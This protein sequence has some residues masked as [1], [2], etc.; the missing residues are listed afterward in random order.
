MVLKDRIRWFRGATH[1]VAAIEFALIAPALL[2]IYVGGSELA[3]GMMNSRRVSLLARTVA[4]LTSLGDTAS[5]MATATMADIFKASTLVLS[6]FPATGA[7]MR[8][9]AIGIYMVGATRTVRI[10]SSAG[11]NI[12]ALPAGVAPPSLKVPASY[13]RHG[14][15]L[16]VSE[17]TMA[18]S[19]MMGNAYSKLVGVPTGAFPL[20][21]TVVWPVRSGNSVTS[22]ADDEIVL[23]SGAAC[24]KT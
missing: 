4:D 22:G 19:P 7:T 16:I 10:C 5:P 17:V 12:A 21:D 1:G 18:Y 9:S 14:M 6:P 11:A 23:P 3:R 8:V 20:S 13:N 15:R 24:P 2:A